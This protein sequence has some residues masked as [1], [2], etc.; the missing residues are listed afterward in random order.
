MEKWVQTDK[1]IN[2]MMAWPYHEM[3]KKCAPDS[4]LDIVCG[5][6]GSC[7]SVYK[8]HESNHV[9]VKRTHT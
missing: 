9:L 6:E 5:S 3:E 7:K 4:R 8:A 1:E 2:T